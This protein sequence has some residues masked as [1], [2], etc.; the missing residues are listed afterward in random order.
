MR[1]GLLGD[2][3]GN[4]LALSAVLRAVVRCEVDALCLPGD[5]VGYYYEPDKV[6]NMLQGWTLYAVRG[7]HEDMFLECLTDPMAV[8]KYRLRYGS[9]LNCA[10]RLL[11]STDTDFIRRLPR[12]LLLELDGKNLLLAHGTPWDTDCYLY[13]D[14]EPALW[15]K[16]AEKA[17]DYIV[18]GHTH[19][20][21]VKRLGN[22]LVINPGSVGQPRDRQSGAAWAVLDTDT[23]RFE[24]RTEPYDIAR[25]AAQARSTDP[26]LPY[27][28]EVLS[29]Q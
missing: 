21:F 15:D 14:T 25:V 13:Q 2:I 4:A 27:L 1:L 12:T 18:L 19:H 6:F 26:H 17:Y 23:G 9:G 29:R 20:R 5:F 10:I 3:H 22:T 24:H 16:V 7:N 28:W 11:P 8:E